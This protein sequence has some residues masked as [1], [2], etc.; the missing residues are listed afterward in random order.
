M[1]DGKCPCG[2]IATTTIDAWGK[3]LPRCEKCK[4]LDDEMKE[5]LYKGEFQ[6]YAQEAPMTDTND[7]PLHGVIDHN[8]GLQNEDGTV[9]Y[10]DSFESMMNSY[11]PTLWDLVWHYNLGR[12][13]NNAYWWVR[14]RTVDR[15]NI[16]H[17]KSLKPGY[18]DTDTRLLHS[19]F[20]L[21]VEFVEHEWVSIQFDSMRYEGKI[22]LKWWQMKRSYIKAHMNELLAAYITDLKTITDEDPELNKEL[23]IQA[24]EKL[25]I[26]ALY[27]WYKHLRPNRKDPIDLWVELKDAGDKEALHKSSELE[28]AQEADDTDHMIRLVKIRERLW[29]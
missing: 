16:V 15:Y 27:E 14:H 12:W 3:M 5:D 19:M 24:S 13:I 7:K 20:D 25:E 1:T 21:L 11:K 22:K 8:I 2:E 10:F 29:T 9:T 6:K 18:Y 23:Q 17:I 26:V 28:A 4:Q